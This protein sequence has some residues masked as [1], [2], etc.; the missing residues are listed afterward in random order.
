[1]SCCGGESLID[2]MRDVAPDMGSPRAQIL[3]RGVSEQTCLAVQ[4][5]MKAWLGTP[6]HA[7]QRARK[8]GVDC[9]QLIPALLDMLYKRPT[10]TPLARLSQD[11]GTHSLRA[12]FRTVIALRKQF[13]TAVVR[14]GSVQA[15]DIALVNLPSAGAIT[16]RKMLRHAMMVG[17]QPMTAIHALHGYEV[18][19]TSLATSQI[20]RVYR[21]LGKESWAV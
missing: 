4:K 11:A 12:G 16:G 15:G 10:P 18:C 13:P 3:W 2:A 6:Y 8:I 21:P 1:M 7:G 5:A 14:D 17:T 9:A 19:M 20:V